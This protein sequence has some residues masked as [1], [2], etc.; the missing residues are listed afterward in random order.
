MI[1]RWLRARDRVRLTM[2]VPDLILSGAKRRL[3]AALESDD[4]EV[5]PRR[6]V[7]SLQPDLVWYPWNGMTWTSSCL[8]LATVHDVWPFV[9][10]A[11]DLRTRRREQTA[12]VTM[13]AHTCGIIANSLFTKSEIV[14]YL[15]VPKERIHVVHMGVDMP[16][17]H[18]T[19]T[20]AGQGSRRLALDGAQRYVLFVGESEPRKDLATLQAAMDKLPLELQA[21]TGLVTAGKTSAN[22]RGRIESEGRAERGALALHFDMT[23]SVPTLIGGEV[24]DAVLEQLYAGAAAFAFPS[25]Y[26]G[27]GLPLLEAMAH[28]VPVVASNAASIPEVGGEAALYVPAGDA[29]ALALALAHVLSDPAV[30]RTLRTAGLAR[31]ADVSW[32]RCSDATLAVFGQVIGAAST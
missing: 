5:R 15:N 3:A 25:R 1:S 28:G 11:A 27:F 12:Y 8:S 4:I 18:G 26:E 2:L 32:D 23:T 13:A 19:Q 6:A 14:K 30:A 10:P 31:A 22:K 7:R 24:S 17:A 16:R 9:S 20:S 21:T 29:G